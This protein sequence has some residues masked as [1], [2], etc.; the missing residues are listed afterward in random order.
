MIFWQGKEK[1]YERGIWSPW[2]SP[3]PRIRSHIKLRK[4]ILS[5]TL[6]KGSWEI[7]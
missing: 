3:Y 2:E 5:G 4:E 1:R 7:L 6:P